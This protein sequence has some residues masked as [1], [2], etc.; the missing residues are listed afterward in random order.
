ML[1]QFF[2]LDVDPNKLITGTYEPWL[3][4]VSVFLASM[5]S[6]FALRLAETARHIEA[7]NQRQIALFSGAF[8]MAGGIWSM[9]FV[10]MLAFQMPHQMQYDYFL[11]AVSLLPAVFS[12]YIVL[13]SLINLRD[14]FVHNLR[15][16]V[17]VG[18]GIGMMHYIGMEAMQMHVELRYDPFWF[19]LSILVSVSLA[20]V[21]LMSR[22]KLLLFFPT[23]SSI[24]LK[25]ITSLIM[26]C[27][28][29]GMHYTGMEAA[30]FIVH[31][32]HGNHLVS[33]SDHIE[34]AVVVSIFALLI[35]TLAVNVSS[36]LRYRQLLK[37]KT[38][39]EAR[40]QAILETAADGV[41][42]TDS[43]GVVQGI[44][45]AARKIFGWKED[46]VIGRNVS[47]L[48]PSKYQSN[49]KRFLQ[50]FLDQGNRTSPPRELYAR[51]RMGELIPVRVAVGRVD[52]EGGQTLFV[53]FIADISERKVMEEKLRESEQRLSSLMQNTP[54]A[55]F[56]R[57]LDHNWTPVFLSEGIFKFTGYLAEDFLSGK[58]DFASC[59]YEGQDRDLCSNIRANI[60]DRGAYEIEY[61][62][63]HKDG[64]TVWVLEN[65][66]LV[67][68][69]KNEAVWT[70]GIMVDIS[71]RK[72]MEQELLEAKQRAEH[73]S[74][75]KSTFLANM[76]HEIRT[77][78]NAIIGF[79][80]ILM[81]S[82]IKGSDR[83]HLEAVSRASRSLLHL[84]ND[85]LDSAKL[86]KNKLELESIP[87]ELSA[88]VDSV[89]STLW[90]S[91]KH[92]GIEL[93][94]TMSDELP[95]VVDGAE[96][97]I[98]QVLMNLVGNGIKFTEK[99]GVTLSI[100]PIES[101]PDWIRFDVIDTGIG[102]KPERLKAIFEPFTQADASMSRRFGGT[103]LGTTISQQLVELMGGSITATS[104]SGKGSCF[105]VELPLPKSELTSQSRST[106]VVTLPQLR[107]L[108]CDDIEQNI[109]LLRILLERQGHVIFTAQDGI[110]AVAQ[111]KKVKP[112]IVLMDIQMP[113]LDGLGACKHI[114]DWEQKQGVKTVPIIALTANVLA[115]DRIQAKQAGMN[116]FA[117]K[118]VDLAQLTQEMA[119]VL[120]INVAFRDEISLTLESPMGADQFHVV[121][122]AKA[123]KLWGD[124]QLYVNELKTLIEKNSDLVDRI[125]N[126][127][128]NDNHWQN[129]IERAHALK[130]ISGNLA[131]IPMYHAFAS[132]EKAADEHLQE[133]ALVALN[134]AQKH[135]SDLFK[136]IEQLESNCSTRAPEM[137]V[138]TVESTNVLPLL[139][140]WL[141]VTRSGE[142]SDEL[143][144]QLSNGAPSSVKKLISDTVNALDDF[145]FE[146]AERY[147]NNAIETLQQKETV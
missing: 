1:E 53:G 68:N 49:Y 37:E 131:L 9:H 14:S 6:F 123:M 124:E 38:E 36:Q 91:A 138:H 34:L 24:H 60:D 19:V 29:S 69:A 132:L 33:E 96:D 106:Q 121:N 55:S 141:M 140:E 108:V 93:T 83:K 15:N 57:L 31:D 28:I 25:L 35:S 18:L 2:V 58:A 63:I 46:E 146:S 23:L 126:Q 116:G 110:E 79:T 144:Q 139:Q 117:N 66:M 122:M 101:K 80:D 40:L 51:H 74:E 26:G 54:G 134:R 78:M 72:V 47:M 90:L 136:D 21:A 20:T 59:V 7:E 62:L 27:A 111:Y 52:L 112:D 135:W 143:A 56:R 3:V 75:I 100:S 97:R 87:F 88:C 94:L 95:K 41:V 67:R 120:N 61:R 5:S 86:E 13:S 125:F 82:D 76:S 113:L 48:M 65:G 8:I 103:G 70:D 115:E 118:P 22:S 137:I 105:T 128:I 39:G 89:I 104:Q 4:A 10:G 99:G 17:I 42:T 77:P 84:L 147:I 107:I 85:I 145:D 71:S 11:T 64:H 98:R 102:I 119:S 130:G 109:N 32:T 73:A 45:S 129:I 127:L 81:D 142:V 133:Q 50:Q 114:R 44:N 12:S 92:K 16:G 43:L 30:R